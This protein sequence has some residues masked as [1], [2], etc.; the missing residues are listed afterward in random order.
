MTRAL[1]QPA[2]PTP[3]K[4]GRWGVGF[5]LTLG[6]PLLWV[7][8]LYLVPLLL[9]LIYAFWRYDPVQGETVRTFS[10]ENFREI[11]GSS[12]YLRTIGRTVLVA[13]GVT[14]IDAI[15]SLPLA[16]FIARHGGRHRALL[17]LLVILPLWSSYLV[18][19]FAWKVILGTNGVLNGFLM[20]VGVL[21]EPSPLFLYS[22]FAVVLTFVH[23]WLPFMILP[24][25][26]AFER[27]PQSLLE[28]GGDLGARPSAVFWRVTLPMV[29]PG[30]L[31]GGL[32]VFSLTMGDFITPSLV[33]GTSSN[34][35]GNLVA[36]QFGVSDNW[37]L[38]AAFSLVVIGIV[39]GVMAVVQR[40]AEAL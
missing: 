10:L 14:L 23:V 11:F 6:L 13:A 29:F 17:T 3:R 31:A 2:L 9:L 21:H 27:L 1:P 32:S 15:I 30:L 37:P 5:S 39:V 36:T 24:L 40:R 16:Y 7:T 34:Q 12:A 38:G 22:N 18:R 33:G 19:A 4:S 25:I 8:V 35:V 20:A 26:T 28:V